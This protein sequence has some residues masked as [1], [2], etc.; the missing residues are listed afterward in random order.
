MVLKSPVE[1]HVKA[2]ELLTK[3]RDEDRKIPPKAGTPLTLKID[4]EDFVLFDA[5]RSREYF[6]TVFAKFDV[7][8]KIAFRSSSIESVRCNV[9]N[10]FG[11]SLLS[12]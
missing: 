6:L 4:G 9:A 3:M 10:G 12:S 5:P 2:V 1:R 7:T 11:V 8:P